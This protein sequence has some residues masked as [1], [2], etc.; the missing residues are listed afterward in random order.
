MREAAGRVV[1]VL[2]GLDLLL[3]V[4]DGHLRA[5]C[6]ES[7]KYPMLLYIPTPRTVDDPITAVSKPIF[8]SKY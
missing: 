8:A 2:P 5:P 4:A 6:A 1:L 7:R 3:G